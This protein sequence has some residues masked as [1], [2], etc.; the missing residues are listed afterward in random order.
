M[1]VARTWMMFLL[2]TAAL[3]GCAGGEPG[4][5]EASDPEF[6]NLELTA[7]DTTG[8]LRGVVVDEA[9]RPV[10]NASVTLSGSGTGATVTNPDGLFGFSGLAPGPYFVKVSKAGFVE[11]QTSAEVA[12]GIDEPDILR[13]LLASDPMT[14]PYVTTYVF[15]GYIECSFSLVAVGFA[16]C[17]TAEE[18]N[19]R[20][21]VNYTLDRP[22]HWVQSEMAWRST[23]AVS[24]E[25]DVV[26]SASGEGALLDNYAEDWGPSPLL[27]QVN[28]TLAAERGLGS[29]TDLLIRVFNQPVEGTETGDPTDGDD[30]LDRPVLGGCTTGAGM[31]IEQSFTIITNV[32]YGFA[33]APEWRYIEEG[34]HPAP[35]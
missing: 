19:D 5:G 24:P 3:A 33:P 30:C 31:T 10:A 14:A 29:G 21:I 9:I 7:T 17:S 32:F 8:V 26:Y 4:A 2:A 11:G 16:A 23:Q 34:P 28:E 12:A 1:G 35:T 15:E 6:E 27:V 18:L 25:L 22:P 13:V 20:F